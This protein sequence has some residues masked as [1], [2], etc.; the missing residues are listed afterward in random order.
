[1]KN[2][3]VDLD[4]KDVQR[5]TPDVETYKTVLYFSG[6]MEPSLD[7][8]RV[9]SY[10]K[11]LQ[12]CTTEV[13]TFKLF[14]FQC[15]DGMFSHQICLYLFHVETQPVCPELQRISKFVLHMWNSQK[16]EITLCQ[17]ASKVCPHVICVLHL[18]WKH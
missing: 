2:L 9:D 16:L 17:L 1:M 10:D 6:F 18:K 5:C 15:S 14:S 11:N 8:L 12:S 7:N 3:S 13:E 4:S